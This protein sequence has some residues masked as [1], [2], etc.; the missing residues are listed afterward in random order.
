MGGRLRTGGEGQSESSPA[1][2]RL[3]RHGPATVISKVNPPRLLQGGGYRG[4]LSTPIHTPVRPACTGGGAAGAARCPVPS[5]HGAAGERRALDTAG[6][7]SSGV[8]RQ[9]KGSPL[10]AGV[11]KA[12][13]WKYMLFC[14]WI[15]IKAIDI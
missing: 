9:A 14:I 12:S 7:R 3:P 15:T 8:P 1:P 2:G 4:S 10:F 6:N 13:K 5:P 11:V